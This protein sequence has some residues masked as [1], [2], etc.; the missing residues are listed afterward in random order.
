[1]SSFLKRREINKHLVQMS[2]E[3][4]YKSSFS[5]KIFIFASLICYSLFSVSPS[6][7]WDGYDY[8]NKTAVEIGPGNLVREGRVIQFYDVKNNQFYTVKIITQNE[9]FHGTELVVEDVDTKKQRTLIM[10]E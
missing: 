8:N 7:A 6:Y 4:S 1:M 9:I 3:F 2:I 10:K 5:K